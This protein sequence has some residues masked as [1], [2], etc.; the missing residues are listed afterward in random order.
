MQINKKFLQ[1]TFNYD[2]GEFYWKI[3]FSDKT[4]IGSKA[5]TEDKRYKKITLFGKHYYT[6]RL[7]YIYHFGNFK[8]TIDHIDRNKKNNKIENLRVATRTQNNINIGKYKKNLTSKYKGVC[9]YKGKWLAKTSLNNKNILIGSFCN[10]KDAAIAYNNFVY[11]LH[12]K[13]AF[14]NRI[15]E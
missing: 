2:D 8:G 14:I 15:E 9:F 1:K 5:G 7:I 10:E 3:K 12:G 11:N 13:F 4:M 6:H